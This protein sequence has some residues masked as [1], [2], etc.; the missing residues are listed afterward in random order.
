MI[1][2]FYKS[3]LQVLWADKPE[4]KYQAHNILWPRSYHHILSSILFF[5]NIFQS[6]HT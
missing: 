2:S 5:I 4:D 6:D 1:L 3:V